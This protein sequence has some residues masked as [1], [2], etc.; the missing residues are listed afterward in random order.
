M[1][2]PATATGLVLALL[3]ADAGAA[4]WQL[5]AGATLEE[6]G[7]MEV[8]LRSRRWEY[9]IG[10]VSEQEVLVR[11]LTPTCEYVGSPAQS[12]STDVRRSREPVDPYAYLSVQRR[13]EFLRGSPVRPQAGLG[14][15]VQSDTNEYVSTPVNFSLSLGLAVGERLAVEWRHFSNGD[16]EGHNL[17][18]DAILLR[19]RL[20]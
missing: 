10:W 11:Y 8:A 2:L 9:A 3:A 4:D 6:G 1:R 15:V 19:W 16:A 7:A 13:F 20:H 18:Q 14:L 12:C 17:G 5:S